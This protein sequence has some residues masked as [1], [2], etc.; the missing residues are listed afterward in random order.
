[1]AAFAVAETALRVLKPPA[2]S[3]IGYPCVY[4]PDAELGFRYRAGA[5]GRV[6]GHFE[7]DNAVELNSLGFYDDEPLDPGASDLRLLAVGDSFTA[8]M[9]VAR[10]DVWTSVLEAELRRSGHPRADVVNIGIDGTGTDVHLELLR[11]Y[12]PRF[13]P[14]IVLVAF[15]A[16]DADDV[17]D[18]RFTRE[19]HAGYV[20]SYQTPAQRD[21]LRARVDQH[22]ERSAWRFAFERS[23]LVRLGTALALGPHNLFRLEFVA[24]RRAELERG[25]DTLARRR[26]ALRGSFEG[27]EALGR[28]CACR[29]LMVPV[30]ARRELSASVRILRSWTGG[31]DLEVVDVLPHMVRALEHDGRTPAD[32]FFVHD[33]HLNTYGNELFGRAVAR[34]LA[35]NREPGR[36]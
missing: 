19:C 22:L 25:P 12:V 30:P 31:L 20:L 23:Y 32:L 10:P 13:E 2:A 1:M 28:D 11:R 26:V 9:N 29:L 4:V 34:V 3:R 24:P 7:I 35:A 15:F 16:N 33:N 14:D 18:G 8:A 36:R 5:R 21:G 6:A 17:L 27:L